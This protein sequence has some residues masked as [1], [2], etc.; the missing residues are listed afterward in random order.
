M[1]KQAGYIFGEGDKLFYADVFCTEP[2]PVVVTRL[3]DSDCSKYWVRG[4]DSCEDFV[5]KQHHLYETKK[6]ALTYINRSGLLG[7]E[8]REDSGR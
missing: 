6:E 7:A 2:H 1:S 8:R 4:D 5:A 3:Y